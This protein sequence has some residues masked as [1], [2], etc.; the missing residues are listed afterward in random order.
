[1]RLEIGAVD[2]S[3]FYSYLGGDSGSFIGDAVTT[4]TK[5]KV[6]G[7]LQQ[8]NGKSHRCRSLIVTIEF[9]LPQ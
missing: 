1:V 9:D 8:S 6:A 4:K 2:A 3:D 5:T 7:N